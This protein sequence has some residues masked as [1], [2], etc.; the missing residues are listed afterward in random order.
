[1]KLGVIGAGRIG[2]LHAAAVTSVGLG[3]I[4]SSAMVTQSPMLIHNY[5]ELDY[6]MQRMGPKFEGLLQDKGFVVLNWSDAG[7]MRIFTKG[8]MLVPED[9]AKFKMF[10]FEGDPALIDA[11]KASGMRPVV[12][13]ATDVL[14]SLQSGLLSGF[15]TTPLAALSQQWFALAPHMLDMPWAPLLAA[16]VI[17][18]DTWES[19]PEKYHAE[20][21][22]VAREAGRESAREV[23][24]QDRKAVKVMQKYGLKVH[25]LPKGA[26]ARWQDASSKAWPT[27]RNKM[28]GDAIFSETE[29][30][31]QEY[32]ST[33]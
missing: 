1:M 5:D 15:P 26:R 9:A 31:L 19:I 21:M 8:P 16:T 20:F 28:V 17:R 33:K 24:R 27:I 25:P 10:A 32:R 11:Y 14:P 18:K 22:Q 2:Q 30:Y 29:R 13:A 7:W 6:I 3:D 23:R 4:E 12:L